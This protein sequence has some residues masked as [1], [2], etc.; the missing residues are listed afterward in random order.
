MLRNSYVHGK[1]WLLVNICNKK[2]RHFVS[3]LFIYKQSNFNIIIV[4]FYNITPSEGPKKEQQISL[5][6]TSLMEHFQ[7]FEES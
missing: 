2:T 5:I 6:L 1:K 7:S 3:P 4:C